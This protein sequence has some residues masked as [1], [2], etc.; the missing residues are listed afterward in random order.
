MICHVTGSVAH[1]ISR[2]TGSVALGI[3][4]ANSDIVTCPDPTPCEGWGVGTMSDTLTKALLMKKK[5]FHAST[6]SCD[7]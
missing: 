6:E 7:W 5:E 1:A 2:V 4:C 3:S